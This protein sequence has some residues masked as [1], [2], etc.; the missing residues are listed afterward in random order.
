MA[1][2]KKASKSGLHKEV[3]NIWG[4][5]VLALGALIIFSVVGYWYLT[6]IAV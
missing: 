4:W 2:K 6:F 3:N 5:V 1:A